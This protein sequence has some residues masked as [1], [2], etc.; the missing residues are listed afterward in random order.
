MFLIEDEDGE[1]FGFYH[2]D[3]IVDDLQIKYSDRFSFYFNLKSNGRLPTPMK[4]NQKT[5]E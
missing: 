2:N 4:F 1:Q 3:E 5:S